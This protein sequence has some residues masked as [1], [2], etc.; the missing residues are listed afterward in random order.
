[1]A[2]RLPRLGGK[3]CSLAFACVREAFVISL[4]LWVLWRIND[5]GAAGYVCVQWW[6]PHL[7]AS[8]Y[9]SKYDAKHDIHLG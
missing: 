9:A 3:E 2:A 4:V 8:I 5:K 6:K 1:M 7:Y